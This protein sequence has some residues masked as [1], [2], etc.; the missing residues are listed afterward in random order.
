[1]KRTIRNLIIA[2]IPTAIIGAF[3]LRIA[4]MERGYEA[5]GGEWLLIAICFGAFYF[6]A[7]KVS[8]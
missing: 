5:F 8:R 4:Y 6:F 2:A 7:D 3:A 1:M